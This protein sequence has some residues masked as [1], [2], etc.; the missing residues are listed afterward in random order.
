MEL[1]PN[2][3]DFV[4]AQNSGFRYTQRSVSLSHEAYFH[5]QKVLLALY[6]T[7]APCRLHPMQGLQQ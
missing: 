4:Y 6:E 2:I 1:T 7:E 5:S 3:S